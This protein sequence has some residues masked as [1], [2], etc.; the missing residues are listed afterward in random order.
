M[1]KNRLFHY[2]EKE[3]K[4]SIISFFLRFLSLL[5]LTGYLIRKSLYGLGL[6]KPKKL[7]A[8]VISVGNITV[9]GSG[10]TPFVLY[11]AKKL[12]EK[13]II[14]TIL[15]R[16]YK[17]LS[18][19]TLELKKS[20]SLHMKWEQAGDEPYLLSNHLPGVPIIVDKDRFHSG[21][22][23]QD[24]YKADFLL[25]DDGFQHWRLKRDLDIVM[26]DSSIDLKKEK[27]LP[28]GRLR[29]PLSSLNRANL[30]VLTRVDQ[31]EHRDKVK[32]LLQKYNPQ[33]P[34]VESILQ[35]SSIQ[36]WKDKTEISLIQFNGKKGL[37]FC[38]IGNPF[39]FERTLKSLGL[40]ILN[41]FFFL[42]HYIYTRKDLLLLQEEARK[43]GAEYL[44]TTEKD[45]IRLPDTGELTIP[46]LVVK[47][48]LKIIS[49]EEKLWEVLNI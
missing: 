34:I 3:D 6:I 39:S 33:A 15:T 48:E 9:G 7:S 29:E 45:S 19:E 13:G 25:L 43:S 28:A 20:D 5:Y 26:I 30:F 40:E 17:R 11:L 14:F 47:V 4:R 27:L 42:D 10:K 1:K 22:I 37:A 38:G 49:G 31:S 32:K 2:W 44:I 16:G 23:A 8:K 35:T 24:K 41:A 46:L 36:N 21:T 18:K 12:Q